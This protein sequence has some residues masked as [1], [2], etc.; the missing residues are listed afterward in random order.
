MDPA[1]KL[2]LVTGAN[3]GIGLALVRRL[4]AERAD[5]RVLLGARDAAR[6]EAARAALAAE[7]PA[8]AARVEVLPSIPEPHKP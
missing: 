7:D 2:V 1:T 5:V 3:K 4:L 8:W 6:G